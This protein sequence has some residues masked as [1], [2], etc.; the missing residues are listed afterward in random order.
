MSVNSLGKNMLW[1]VISRIGAQAMLAVSNI[2]LARYLGGSGF[3]E[4]A[5]MSAV[6]FVGNAFSSFGTDMILI[7]RISLTGDLSELPAG[8]AVQ[9]SLSMVFIIS[10][11]AVSSFWEMTSFLPFFILALIPLSLFTISTIALRGARDM[12]GFSILHLLSAFLH[13]LSVVTLIVLVSGLE[14]FT[15]LFLVAQIASALF[16][17]AL[18]YRRVRDFP[19][20]WRFSWETMLGLLKASLGVAVIGTLRLVHEKLAT[21][22]LPSL[23][24]IHTTGLF[25]A[26]SRVLDA[27]KLGHMAALTA[28]YPEMARVKGL[29]PHFQKEYGLL[30]AGAFV[31]SVLLYLLAPW[32]VRLLFG[33]SY[34][35][36]AAALQILAWAIIPYFLVSHYSLAFIAIEVER[37]VLISLLAALLLLVTMLWGWAPLH[38]LR[39]AA[40]AVLCAE[41]AQAIFLWLQW[42]WHALSEST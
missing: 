29:R 1:T 12:Q 20:L 9:L 27:G 38:G 24:G 7:R 33:S 30:L 17:F 16:G 34:A 15:A 42:R 31:L 19:V 35:S 13:L 36:S 11:F 26:S 22:L 4:Y 28:V 5:F 39:G 41:G 21:I 37:P 8:L 25:S 18:C 10:V 14:Q 2:L 6:L 23:A 40:W 3:G 32:I